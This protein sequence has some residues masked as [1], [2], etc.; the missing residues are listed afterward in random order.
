V[1]IT[2]TSGAGYCKQT[3]T[4]SRRHPC[5]RSEPRRSSCTLAAHGPLA[6]PAVGGAEMC[7]D[8]LLPRPARDPWSR[9]GPRPA[10]TLRTALCSFGVARARPAVPVRPAAGG[11]SRSMRL[12]AGHAESPMA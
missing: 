12:V 7:V 6:G 3:V 8:A 9:L 10:V 1:T 11:A 5:D 2:V 4:A